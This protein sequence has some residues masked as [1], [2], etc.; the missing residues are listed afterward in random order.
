MLKHCTSILNVYLRY[1][2]SAV[3][4]LWW[5]GDDTCRCIV[6]GVLFPLYYTSCFTRAWR[7]ARTCVLW[8]RACLRNVLFTDSHMYMDSIP[9]FVGMWTGYRHIATSVPMMSKALQLSRIDFLK[10]DVKVIAST[11]SLLGA[12][13]KQL[14]TIM[15]MMRKTSNQHSNTNQ[16]VCQNH[17]V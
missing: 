4:P 1:G 17:A 14:T 7:S 16:L 5:Y 9:C 15:K 12:G 3:G 8:H 6:R 2:W 13:V 10:S 11:C